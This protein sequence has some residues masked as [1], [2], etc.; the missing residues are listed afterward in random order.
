MQKYYLTLFINRLIICNY[1]IYAHVVNF[2]KHWKTKCMKEFLKK[3][4]KSMDEKHVFRFLIF[5]KDNFCM[6]GRKHS[7]NSFL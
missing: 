5:W 2:N 4:E 6:K 1:V 3:K 7:T